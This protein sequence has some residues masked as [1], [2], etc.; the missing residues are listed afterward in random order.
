MLITQKHKYALRALF[1]LAL[2]AGSGPVKLGD[3]ADAQ[4]IP[5]RFLEV[6]MGQLRHR[7]LVESKRGFTGGYR[8]LKPAGQITVGEIFRVLDPP[9]DGG[10]CMICGNEDDCP[11]T[12][13]C[14]F[15][16][17]WNRVQK[18]IEDVYHDTTIED[19]VRGWELPTGGG[20]G[21]GK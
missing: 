15:I 17:L 6:I 1:E 13:R 19:L 3:I 4:A 18:A 12:G 2:H 14:A 16:T 7:G 21:K 11:L 8:L 20:D 5:R 10:R 9:D